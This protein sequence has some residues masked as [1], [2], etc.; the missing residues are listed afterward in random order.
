MGWGPYI[1]RG[2]PSGG[3]W[4]TPCIV[5]KF[6]GHLEIFAR[7]ITG[8]NLWNTWTTDGGKTWSSWNNLGSPS[9]GLN[10]SP[11]V[12][13]RNANNME[14]FVRGADNQLWSKNW[15]NGWW[16]NGWSD[17]NALGGVLASHPGVC[18]TGNDN[19]NV[20]IRGAEDYQWQKTWDGTSW[21]DYISQGAYY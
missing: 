15:N 19:I 9:G 5:S 14:V 6:S 20:F 7:S 11:V 17:W 12:T 21:S 1:S 3:I 10:S 2:A 8:D 4:G 16:N 18:S 13:S